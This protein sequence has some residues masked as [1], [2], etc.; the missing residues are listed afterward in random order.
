MRITGRSAFHVKHFALA[1]NCA[2][3]GNKISCKAGTGALE[4]VQYGRFAAGMTGVAQ[5]PGITESSWK[6]YEIEDLAKRALRV[7]SDNDPWP[8]IRNRN[9]QDPGHR[10]R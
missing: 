9:R 5:Q 3:L 4:Y 2:A 6:G 10:H 8:P 7:A 1:H